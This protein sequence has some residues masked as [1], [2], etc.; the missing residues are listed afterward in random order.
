MDL[1]SMQHLKDSVHMKFETGGK[2]KRNKV[3]NTL[4]PYLNICRKYFS[5]SE[6]IFEKKNIEIFY[7]N[8][9][10]FLIQVFKKNIFMQDHI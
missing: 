5:V 9:F 4:K 10:L 2:L 3:K 6:E 1:Q 7:K 8:I